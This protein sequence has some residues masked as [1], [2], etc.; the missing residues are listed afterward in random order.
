[1]IFLENC[2]SASRFFFLTVNINLV[3]L[4][5]AQAQQLRLFQSQDNFWNCLKFVNKY[6][7]L[8]EEISGKFQEN[9]MQISACRVPSILKTVPSFRVYR[10][11]ILEDRAKSTLFQVFCPGEVSHLHYRMDIAVNFRLGLVLDNR[12]SIRKLSKGYCTKLLNNKWH[13]L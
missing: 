8:F 6:L 2:H 12:M 5:H 1:M 11:N 10:N 13:I 9:Q 3:T 4:L 7:L